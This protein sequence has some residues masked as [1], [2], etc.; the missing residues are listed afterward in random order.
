MTGKLENYNIVFDSWCSLK[1]FIVYWF[2]IQYNVEKMK[3][4]QKGTSENIYG[5]QKG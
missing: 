4:I 3:V 1:P 5:I 2:T